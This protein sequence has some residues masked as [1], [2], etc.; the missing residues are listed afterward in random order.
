MEEVYDTGPIGLASCCGTIGEVREGE[1]QAEAR[2]AVFLV[3][4]A[5]GRAVGLDAHS[6]PY[7]AAH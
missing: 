4:A 3:L 5:A 1:S 7:A 2:E 6:R